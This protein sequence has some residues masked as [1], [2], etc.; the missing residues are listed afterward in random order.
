MTFGFEKLRSKSGMPVIILIASA[1]DGGT[2]VP[3]GQFGISFN[4]AIHVARERSPIA[5]ERISLFPCLAITTATH[6]PTMA[7]ISS[8]TSNRISL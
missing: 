2:G 5:D 1:G 6:R 7:R 4:L 8:V 3:T